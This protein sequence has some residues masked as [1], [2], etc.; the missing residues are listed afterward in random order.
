M[1]RITES[2][3]PDGVRAVLALFEGPL[4]VMRS[5]GCLAV[6]Q[7]IRVVFDKHGIRRLEPV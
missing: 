7:R 1:N 2:P 5:A 6:L 3:I 4:M